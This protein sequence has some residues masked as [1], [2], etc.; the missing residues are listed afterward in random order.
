MI[1]AGISLGGRTDIVFV[2]GTLTAQRYVDDIL[3]PVVLPYAGAIGPGFILQDDNATPH[4]SRVTNAFIEEEG[5]ERMEWPAVSPDLNPIE[6]L[7]DE[8]GR[9]D[10]ERLTPES[11]EQHLRDLLLEEWT[12]IPQA[13]VDNLINSMRRRCTE[14]I[15]AQGGHTHYK[16]KVVIFWN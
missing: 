4:R 5:L 11:T 15:E 14:C 6:H 10:T 13:V 2:Q 1:W 9:A 7:W 8:L 3:R 16:G 12:R